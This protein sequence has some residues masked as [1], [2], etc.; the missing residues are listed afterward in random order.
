[1][2]SSDHPCS[3]GL[4]PEC[5]EAYPEWAKLAFAYKLLNVLIPANISRRLPKG[6]F[7]GQIG[8]GAI[9]PP[10]WIPPPGVI[11]PPNYTVPPSWIPFT[12]FIL[13]EGLTWA[14][15]FPEGWT[16][17]DPLPPGVEIDTG[18]VFP[19]GWTPGDP[20]PP[21]V[22]VPPGT[23]FPPGWTPG[24]PLPPGVIIDTVTIL[25]PGWTP[26]NPPPPWFAPDGTGPQIPPGGVLPPLYLPP[27]LQSPPHVSYPRSP[28]SAVPWFYD[29]FSGPDVDWTVW[30][31][32]N[33]LNGF[34]EIVGG[35]L[36]QYCTDDD[37]AAEIDTAEDATIPAAFE[38]TF[39]LEYCGAEEF[40]IYIYTGAHLLDISWRPPHT[41][42]R[43]ITPTGYKYYPCT[44]Y[45][46]QNVSW[47]LVYD[48][49]L[50]SLY[51]DN[52]LI[53][54]NVAPRVKTI[55]PGIIHLTTYETTIIY[56]DNLKI[57]EI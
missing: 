30:T 15:A 31:E 8:P 11:V 25:P 4:T 36:K 16:A 43:F 24:D 45:L 44:D 28:V 2:A 23:V 50:A 55:T 51:Q 33:Y 20:L 9:L 18:A 40:E 56:L 37:S 41:S 42:I 47:K 57:Q 3:G 6:L 46:N 32:Y 34:N 17:E 35:R 49:T 52:V 21:G 39:D 19:P 1:M 14:E 26:E 5:F 29:Q 53:F 7:P 22:I 13:P 12:Y 54:E 10:G 48:G 38:L 27:G